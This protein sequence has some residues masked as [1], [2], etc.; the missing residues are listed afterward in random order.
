MSALPEGRFRKTLINDSIPEVECGCDALSWGEAEL[1]Q[2]SAGCFGMTS[3]APHQLFLGWP[4]L[5]FLFFNWDWAAYASIDAQR[6][7]T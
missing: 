1:V 4:W 5:N 2:K 7:T 3:R 6:R